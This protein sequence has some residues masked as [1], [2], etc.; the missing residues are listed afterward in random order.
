[1]GELL[2]LR[3]E[4]FLDEGNIAGLIGNA[5]AFRE[6]LWRL[7]QLANA[8][9]AVLIDGETGTGKELVARAIHGLGPRAADPFVAVNCGSLVDTLFESELF[10]HERGAFTDAHTRRQGL[11]A[12][13]AGGTLFL[14][15][16]DTLTPRGQVALLRALQDR[17]FRP[18]GSTLERRV[19]V[20][21][22][23]A[24][25]AKLEGLVQAGSFRADLYYRL[26]VFSVTLPPLR[27]RREDILPLA[28]HFLAK[29]AGSP[30]P[31]PQLSAG[32]MEVLLAWD[33]PGNV[34]ELES[35]IL[36]ALAVAKGGSL[37][38]GDLGLPAVAG[39]AAPQ[40]EAPWSYKTQKRRILEVFERHYLI[41]LMREHKGNVSRAAHAAGKERRDLGKLL[42]RHGLDPRQFMD[43]AG[44][45]P[46]SVSIQGSRSARSSIE[47]LRSGEA[48]GDLLAACPG[49][50]TEG[51]EPGRRVF[52]P[53][54]KQGDRGGPSTR[55][56]PGP[57]GAQL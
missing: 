21:F 24:T 55:L 48:Y 11:M 36:R 49:T 37:E 53:E 29:Y 1:M 13:A 16:V 10:G 50:R 7:P 9:G 32:A 35:A 34:R 27:E 26:C 39:A 12:Q 25:N 38:A 33:W 47:P 41:R 18:L 56:T 46:R 19:D 51:E 5:P 28:W 20:R 42:K 30:G 8:E 6:V 52:N 17:T 43:K 2:T 31:A 22:L 23:A 40:P 44:S 45:C 54:F 4:R 14:D 57:T 3:S 15:E